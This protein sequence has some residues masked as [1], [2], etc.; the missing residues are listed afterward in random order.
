M[1]RSDDLPLEFRTLHESCLVGVREYVCRARR[2]GPTEE[3]NSESNKIV[4]MRSGAFCKHFGRRGMTADVNQAVFF[5]KGSTYRVSH[6]A[7]CGDR[8]TVLAPA[9][10]VLADIMREI[11]PRFD[12][13]D[14]PFPFVTGPCAKAVYL[15][16]RELVLRLEAA[17]TESLE[18]IWADETALQLVAD[19][20]EGAFARR[21]LPRRKRR[22]DTEAE[23]TELA[24]AVKTLLAERLSERITLDETA[25][26]LDS[27]P[28]H[29]ARVFQMQTGV[30]VH[31]YLSGLRLRTAL[32]RLE[33]GAQDLTALALEFNFS[34]HSHF[35]DAFR[36]EFGFTPSTFRDTR[37]RRA[38]RQLSK[39]LKVRAPRAG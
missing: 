33:Q 25:R 26:A 35:T 12:E 32:D 2:G 17:G 4:L 13:P 37:G 39:N 7:D 22:T 38:I 20:L 6:P 23:H 16:H 29:L 21:G 18:P 28:F 14:Q 9:R 8:G 24:E 15:A 3:E 30:P 19:V 31:R 34:S 27:S 1:P 36:R 5:S 10:S 11:D